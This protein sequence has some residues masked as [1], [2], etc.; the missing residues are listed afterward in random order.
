MVDIQ[1]ESTN[2]SCK[3]CGKLIV[4]KGSLK[5]HEMVCKNNTDAVKFNRSKNAGK[6]KGSSAW[7]KGIKTGRAKYWD[8]KY[9]DNVLFSANTKVSRG[10]IKRAIL[11]RGLIENKCS[12]CGML[13]FWN[14]KPLV[15]V[16]DH[17]NG[18]NNDNRLDNL[19]FVC[20]NCDSQLPTYKG[21]NKG[22]HNVF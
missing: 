12:C 22:K 10:T 11:R 15:F 6:Q 20:S 8:L 3:F 19:R 17:I 7:N 13:P 14:G 9:T 16:L 18:I 5:A 2:M 1:K 21:K 4:N